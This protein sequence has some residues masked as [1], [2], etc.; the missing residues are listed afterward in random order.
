MNLLD[1]NYQTQIIKNL[2]GSDSQFKTI[3]GQD[4]MVTHT[5]KGNKFHV[6][7][8]ASIN[9]L[10]EL[11]QD[12]KYEVD[13][14]VQNN[15]STVGFRVQIGQQAT[16]VGEKMFYIDIVI[17]QN[18]SGKGKVTMFEKRLICTNGMTRTDFKFSDKGL[19]MSHT[20]TYRE[21]IEVVKNVLSYFD[22]MVDG[23]HEKDESLSKQQIN[24]V[25][26]R[27]LLNVWFYNSEL[28]IS[29][30]PD[31]LELF[32]ESVAMGTYTSEKFANRYD[33]LISSMN[34]EIE[35]NSQLNLNISKYT[36]LATVTNYLSQ[37]VRDS[38]SKASTIVVEQRQAT[39][40]DAMLALV[41]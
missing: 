5:H 39:K 32:R 12:S 1:F 34:K 19:R 30:R 35:Y 8:T 29:Q 10:M 23:I 13:S 7:D 27:R 33:N 18:G 2:D 4:G 9:S 38:K 22:D 16:A 15:G 26:L 36:A 6:I 21:N 24:T 11:F 25:E 20:S 31:S 41:G 37:K 28:P 14:W 3:F 17:P 40:A